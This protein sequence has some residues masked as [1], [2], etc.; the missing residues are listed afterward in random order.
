MAIPGA[1]VFHFASG[2]THRHAALEMS[3]S[4]LGVNEVIRKS[5]KGGNT[6]NVSGLLVQESGPVLLGLIK[7]SSL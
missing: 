5:S 1:V 2:H 6:T 4:R 3:P 7:E